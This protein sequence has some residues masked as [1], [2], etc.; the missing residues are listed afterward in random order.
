M[1]P[2]SEGTA[3]SPSTY[4]SLVEAC[5]DF[6][7]D[8]SAVQ[9]YYKLYLPY[10]SHAHGYMLPEVVAKMPWTS[11]F[12]VNHDGDRY[13]SVLDSSHGKDTAAAVNSAFGK[14]VDT[15]V[16]NDLFHLLCARH[17]ESFAIIG[18]TYD[19]PVYVERFAAALFGITQRGA[20]MIA[21]TYDTDRQMRIWVG[22]RS[23]HIYTYPGM[24][25]STVAGGIELG[26]PP[27]KTIIEESGEEASLLEDFV[28]HNVRSRGAISQISL[29]GR[30][31]PGEQG[32][33]VPDYIYLYDIELPADMT[34]KPYD[35]EVGQ[36]HCMT[37]PEVQ[38]ALLNDEFK[39]DSASVM[40]DFLMRHSIITP[41]NEPD[42]VEI[43]M[44]LHRK[45]PFG[46]RSHRA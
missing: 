1:A 41:E 24:L 10:D 9:Q 18:A 3:K 19:Q 27:L 25:D 36:F 33:V 26:S 21:Y 46:I 15:C 37:V 43:T 31:F 5:D 6:P 40:I 8:P 44:R 34:P 14:V 39:P 12:V 13:V 7:H 28:R 42:F 4:L 11:D 17:S 32:L 30:G 38:G 2:K 35:E 23:L 29:T 22:R 16:D 45:L 20:H